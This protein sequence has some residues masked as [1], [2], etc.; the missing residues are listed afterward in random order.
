MTPR[1]LPFAAALLGLLLAGPG[2]R[3]GADRRRESRPRPARP[4]ARVGEMANRVG[5]LSLPNASRRTV[6]NGYYQR[7][8]NR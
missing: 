8:G 4:P 1:N 3:G 5:C 6:V 2:G 7:V